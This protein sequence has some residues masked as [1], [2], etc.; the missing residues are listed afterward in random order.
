MDGM[1]L[2]CEHEQQTSH[3]RWTHPDSHLSDDGNSSFDYVSQNALREPTSSVKARRLLEE[4]IHTSKLVV[5]KNPTAFDH[6][7]ILPRHTLT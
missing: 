6:M 3:N 4:K 1:G 2:R 5:R 7:G